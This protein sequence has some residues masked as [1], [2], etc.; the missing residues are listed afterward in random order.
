MRIVPELASR[1]H[2]IAWS[3]VQGPTA[4]P[5]A[6]PGGTREERRSGS[7][8]LLA[9]YSQLVKVL[10]RRIDL[11][12]KDALDAGSDYG[13]IATACGVSRQAIRQRWLRRTAGSRWFEAWRPVPRPGDKADAQP[14]TRQTSQAVLVRLS[15]G[16]YDGAHDMPFPGEILK[17]EA[18]SP[19]SESSGPVP[20]LAWYLPSHDDA[21]VYDF[22]GVE[23]DARR[24]HTGRL[25]PPGGGLARKPR[26]YQ[27]AAEFGVES[28]VIM[29]E[30]E[31]M[32]EFTRSASSTVEHV[33][34]YKLRQQFTAQAQRK[35]R[36]SKSHTQMPQTPQSLAQVRSG[37]PASMFVP[38]AHTVS[39]AMD[40]IDLA[41]V[42]GVTFSSCVL[43]N[44]GFALPRTRLA[45]RKVTRTAKATGTSSQP[46]IEPSPPTPSLS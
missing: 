43:V 41:R 22:A 46:G 36:P 10:Q 5:W 4:D 40:V 17:Y 19:P 33:I 37:R 7:L 24:M 2:E 25:L 29:T 1:L 42:I 27:L 3:A 21:N 6:S 32:G 45:D 18:D 8:Q 38:S 28:K 20:L 14:R 39:A 31:Q 34:A 12:I 35:P 15:G 11:T 26:V 13:E 23:R 16:P 30:L 44:S 9:V